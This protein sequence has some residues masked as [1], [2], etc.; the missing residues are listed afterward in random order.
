MQMAKHL[1]NVYSLSADVNLKEILVDASEVLVLDDTVY[2]FEVRRHVLLRDCLKAVDRKA[3]HSTKIKVSEYDIW[4]L[5]C[6]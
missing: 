3:F 5:F 1:S 6:T 2:E 4:Y